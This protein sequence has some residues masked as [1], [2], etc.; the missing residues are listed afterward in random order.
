[1]G[2]KEGVKLFYFYIRDL[3]NF[4]P[5]YD[6]EYDFYIERCVTLD[7]LQDG[8]LIFVKKKVSKDLLE[9]L[10]QLKHCLIIVLPS[11]NA[12]IYAKIKL[13]NMVI[14]TDN[15]R[16]NFARIF[17]FIL[18]NTQKKKRPSPVLGRGFQQGQN[19]V[20]GYGTVIEENVMIDHNVVIGDN[21]H[22][23]NNCRI[24]SGVIINDNVVIGDRTII[25]EQSVIGGWGYGFERDEN[26][27]P[28]RLPHIG[29]VIIGHD[30]EVGA[31]TTIASGTFKPTV[32][33]NYTK[34]DDHVH[35]AHNC[36]I[37]EANFLIALSG[38]AGSVTIGDK[39]WIGLNSAVIQSTKIGNDCFIGMG[40]VVKKD[41]PDGVTVSNNPAQ[42]LEELSLKRKIYRKLKKDFKDK[43]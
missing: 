18:N 39:C 25:R 20:I 7:N 38:I 5:D 33:G 40:A 10:E 11:D 28:I 4:S 43:L 37:G 26:G 2:L 29:G 27:I 17:Q 6:N 1:M 36:H 22:I 8:S 13:E 30:V 14:E 41:I 19:V 31:L 12:D 34:I 32:I 21:V 9:K 23:G 16:L 24:M 3:K 42:T 35:V 15:P